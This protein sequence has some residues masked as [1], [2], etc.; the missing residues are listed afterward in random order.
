MGWTPEESHWKEKAGMVEG[1]HEGS[2]RGERGVSVLPLYCHLG[3]SPE[4]HFLPLFN[5]DTSTFG[6][7]R[8]LPQL[9]CEDQMR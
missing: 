9:Y 6:A 8:P 4:L 2:T 3:V 7:F 1:A 5:K